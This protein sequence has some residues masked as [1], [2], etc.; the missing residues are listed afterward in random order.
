VFKIKSS[1]SLEGGVV[2]TSMGWGWVAGT[3]H[4]EFLLKT[5]E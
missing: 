4:V 1:H 3:I 2:T 5:E